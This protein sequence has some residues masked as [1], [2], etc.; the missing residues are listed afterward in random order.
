[1]SAGATFPRLL[2]QL[3]VEYP[4]RH[5]L[6]EKRHGIWQPITWS[7]Y[8]QRV[9]GFAGG[10]ATLGFE[11]GETIALLGDNRPEWLIAELAAQ[12][13]GGS[14]LGL[15]PDG[16]VKEVAHVL[17]QA[18]ARFVMAA[19]QEQVDKL[20]ELKERGAID[21]VS[22]VIHY[23]SRGL[24]GYEQPY[25]IEFTDV[26]RSGC[27]RQPGWWEEQVKQGRPEDVAILCVTAGTTAKPKL[28]ALTHAN[29]LWLGSSLMSEDPIDRDDEVLS[30]LPLAWIGEQVIAIA[31]AL[32]CAFTLSFPES[33]ATVRSD[34]REI[35]PHVLLA[36]PRIWESMLSQVLVRAGDTGRL[37]RRALRWGLDVGRRAAG[38]RLRGGTAAPT[39]RVQLVIAQLVALRP[40]REQLGLTRLR[41][42]YSAGASLAPDVLE[43][44]H[45]IG[46]NLKQIYGLTEICGVAAMHRDGDV[47]L[48]TVG[49]TLPGT[50][51]RI[52]EDGE[53][54]LR[55][56]AVFGGYHRDEQLT[57]QALRNGWLHTK[58]AGYIDAGGQLV[59]ID[60]MKDVMRAPDGTRL[61]P[62]FV[63]SKLR[64]SSDVTEA[65][66]FGGEDR[67]YVTAMMSI[68]AGNVG[69][70]AQRHH[71]SFTT[72]SDLAQMPEVYELIARHVARAN[73]ELPETARVRRFVLLHKQLDADDEELTR[74]RTLRRGV[75]VERY[76]EIVAA[77]YDGA[78]SVTI[79]TTTSRRDGSEIERE[80]TLAIQSM[81]G[82]TVAAEPAAK[83][84]CQLA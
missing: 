68:D 33:A 39:L 55:S 37:R 79:R 48:N 84:G 51:V 61:S 20:V 4:S 69:A 74:M 10:L 76:A 42:A 21:T 56:R 81:D 27:Q 64:F 73:E 40:V 82:L 19:D 65:V 26:E 5:A 70:R 62:T 8:E 52:A 45:A 58:D 46:V 30:F 35:G 63:E 47:R 3:A 29:L 6:R 11:R 9:R 24:E 1:V 7:E 71:L 78:S 12:S 75:I 16:T 50:E 80:I 60:R 14:S 15:H 59:I 43:L 13:L 53:I 18:Q 22:Q 57:A 31:C 54:L 38:A 67:P 72:Y 36:P 66:A 2:C 34:L 49:T 77:L 32:Q 83:H 25:L 41:R 44:F 28:A 23:D 17:A